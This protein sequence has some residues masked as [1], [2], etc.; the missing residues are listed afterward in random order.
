[1]QRRY[2]LRFQRAF[3]WRSAH[4]T[5]SGPEIRLRDVALAVGVPIPS[6]ILVLIVC[7]PILAIAKI[8][9]PAA[10][11]ATAV[12]YLSWIVS[13]RWVASNHS[14]ENLSTKFAPINLKPLLGGAALAVGLLPLTAALAA[15]LEMF[16]SH[17][18]EIPP[19]PLLP[20][21]ISDLPAAFAL[22]IVVGPLAEELLFRGLLLDWLKQ[23]MNVWAASLLLSLLFA[24][25][26]DNGFIYGHVGWVL[27]IQRF[28]VGLGTS[29]LAIRYRTLLPSFAMHATLN[30]IACISSLMS[31]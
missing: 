9:L 7:A 12:L 15:V 1:M 26:H 27:F 18:G 11:A 5:N 3:G 30:G 22:F 29:A 14:W 10:V 4:E 6:T 8:K 25:L 31:A 23:K 16:D 20:H 17:P 13:Y 21:A 28:L 19:S 2:R 24:L